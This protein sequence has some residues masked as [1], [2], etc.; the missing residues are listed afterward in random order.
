MNMTILL[1]PTM[2]RLGPF[3]PPPRQELLSQRILIRNIVTTESG[4]YH[5]YDIVQAIA[6]TTIFLNPGVFMI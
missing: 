5:F 4:T 1:S 2:R 3:P 6:S